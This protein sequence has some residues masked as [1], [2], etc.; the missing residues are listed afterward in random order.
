MLT[1]IGANVVAHVSGKVCLDASSQPV[2]SGAAPVRSMDGQRA[3]AAR[4]PT[5]PPSTTLHARRSPFQLHSRPPRQRLPSSLVIESA[6][7][8]TAIP[9]PAFRAE[10]LPINA[11]DKAGLIVLAAICA[12]LTPNYAGR[13]LI[14]S[15]RLNWWPPLK[16]TSDGLFAPRR[17]GRRG[18]PPASIGRSRS[19]RTS[20]AT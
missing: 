1:G 4:A 17:H 16:P 13:C 14:I 8:S 20:Q 2:T 9:L 10:A 15:L 7:A 12:A 6:S 5:V 3:A 19:G 18:R 11:S